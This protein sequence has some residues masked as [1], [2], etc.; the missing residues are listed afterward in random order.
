MAGGLQI[1]GFSETGTANGQGLRRSSRAHEPRTPGRD[2][3]ARGGD[4]Q[5]PPLPHPQ[6][7]PV[8]AGE[9]EIRARFPE[10]DI[11]IDDLGTLTSG[12]ADAEELEHV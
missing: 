8:Y 1:L 6:G 4:P 12:A 11:V 3:A 7:A 10:G 2:R 9:L 5:P